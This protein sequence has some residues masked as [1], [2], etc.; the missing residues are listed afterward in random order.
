MPKAS[1]DVNVA[2]F[3]EH[4]L[5]LSREYLAIGLKLKKLAERKGLKDEAE[6]IFSHRFDG[7]MGKGM[8]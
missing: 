8:R 3:S 7:L 1:L 6:G 2:E 5:Q 4:Y